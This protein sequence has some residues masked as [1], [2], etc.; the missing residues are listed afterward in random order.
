MHFVYNRP[1]TSLGGRDFKGLL[2]AAVHR[3]ELNAP[4]LDAWNV[5]PVPDGDTGANMLQSMRAAVQEAEQAGDDIAETAQALAKGA[6]HWARGNSGIILSQFWQGLA[7]GL[8]GKKTATSCDLSR[9][10]RRARDLAYSAVSKPAEGTI[11][12]VMHDVAAAAAQCCSRFQDLR[13]FLSRIV[14]AARASVAR[15]PKL[16]AVLQGAGVV[17]SGAQ[18]LLVILEGA[19][20][21]LRRGSAS[22]RY[23][24]PSLRPRDLRLLRLPPAGS[25]AVARYGYCTEFLLR[26]AELDLERIKSALNP[27]GDSLVIAG[28]RSL[29]RVHIHAPDPTAVFTAAG[30]LGAVEGEQ[31]H[32]LD[33]RR[34]EK[35]GNSYTLL[36]GADGR[37]FLRL[38]ENLG[39]MPVGRHGWKRALRRLARRASGS[40]PILLPNSAENI[41]L[42]DRLPRGQ[43]GG[44]AVVATRTIPQGIA[45]ALA[46]DPELGLE[47][48][49]ARMERAAGQ[50]RTIEIQ[51]AGG[52]GRFLGCLDGERVAE[53]P[54]VRRVLELS[55]ERLSAREADVATVYY[56]RLPQAEAAV[57]LLR[58]IYPEIRVESY[59]GGHP[60][61]ELVISI[62]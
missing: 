18:G 23:R 28:G 38:F 60:G 13:A 36:A 42:L 58:S 19:L 41:D 55:L 3:L 16:L 26:G 37:G 48:N 7:Q 46:F 2:Q 14:R 59:A 25:S 17:D 10:F 32:D 12:T 54:G 57:S 8:A 47:V 22:A 29:A 30:A 24:G 51:R 61:C 34:Q 39:A 31:V 49:L 35:A 15:T 40:R 4:Q 20:G 21:Y 43:D 53:G 44:L 62:E 52:N 50:V 27:L 11:L 56:R 33:R 6:L 9:A 5:F 1:M 45:A